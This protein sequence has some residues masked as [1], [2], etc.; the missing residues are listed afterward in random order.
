MFVCMLITSL[1]SHWKNCACLCFDSREGWSSSGSRCSSY[2]RAC[3]DSSHVCVCAPS[4][5]LALIPASWM[6]R[7]STEWAWTCGE[8]FMFGI[9][10]F[11]CLLSWSAVKCVVL[12]LVLVLYCSMILNMYNIFPLF[13]SYLISGWWLLSLRWGYGTCV[14]DCFSTLFLWSDLSLHLFYL[15]LKCLS[16]IPMILRG[17]SAQN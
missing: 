12:V 13:T 16:Y 9:V 10:A 6:D 14:D 7:T 8:E 1:E 11:S 17:F 3:S 5:C 15:C 4:L 2:H